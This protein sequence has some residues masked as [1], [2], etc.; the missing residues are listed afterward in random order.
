MPT[1]FFSTHMVWPS[2]RT[3]SI[4][5]SSIPVRWWG[6]TSSMVATSPL[7]WTMCT[8]PWALLWT[9][10]SNSPQVTPWNTNLKV[11]TKEGA[12]VVQDLCWNHWSLYSDGQTISIRKILIYQQCV[13]QEIRSI[14]TILEQVE[15]VWLSLSKP[16]ASEMTV[17]LHSKLFAIDIN[18]FQKLPVKWEIRLLWFYDPSIV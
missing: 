14:L 11:D 4:G 17:C 9:I 3:T 18:M 7:W 16:L 1:R 6:R 5:Q 12:G 8:S 13:F 10:P 2:L 15:E